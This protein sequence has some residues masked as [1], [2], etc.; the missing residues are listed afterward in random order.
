MAVPEQAQVVIYT[1]SQ[2]AI[3]NITAWN[4]KSAQTKEKTTNHCIL[5]R[6]DQII[7]EK[8]ISLELIKVKGHSNILGNEEANRLAAEGSSSNI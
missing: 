3:D 8:K 4:K 1:D 6:I 2:C 5:F 7:K